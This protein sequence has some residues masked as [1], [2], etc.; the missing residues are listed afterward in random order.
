MGYAQELARNMKGFQ[1][2]AISFSIICI[3]SGGINSLGQ[4]IG[5]VGGAAIGIGWILGCGVS[6][7]FALGMA[8]IGSA[9]P[10]AGGLYHWSST[11][12]G[13]GYGWLTA[14]LNLIGLVT[15]L[16]AINVGTYNFFIGAFGPSLGL[17]ASFGLQA[18]FVIGITVIQS[19]VNHVG[20]RATAKLTDLSGYLIFAVAV[21]LTVALLAYA[22]SWEFS[23]LWTFKNYSGPAGGDVWPATESMLFLFGLGLLLPI[24]TITGFDASAHTA[25]ETKDAS[26]AV[27]KGI[28]NSVVW[29]ALFGWVM[30]SAF[31]LAIP[32]MDKAAASGWGVFFFTL[33]AVLPGALK[34]VLYVLIFVCQFI[35]GLATVTSASRMIFAFARDGGLPASNALKRVHPG[36]RTPVAAIWTAALI[37]IAFTLYT[38]AYATIVSVTVIFIFIS[39]GLPVIA[40][41]FAYG[42]TW[43]QM[44]PWDMGPAYRVVG[45]LAIAAIALI[46]YLGV[47]PPN[48]AALTITL[49]FLAIT[50]V[51][52]FGFERRRFKGPPV[53]DEVAKRQAEIAAAENALVASR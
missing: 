38:P 45:V 40:G 6:F 25:E 39:Y 29:S 33:D 51:V 18:A 8:Q 47:Q 44:G 30:L 21:G 9:Y 53:G 28:I 2:F 14:W 49:V 22:P 3:L 15:V 12:G 24:Y 16:G 34:Q 5:G 43:T 13:R 52:W 26:R 48:G 7:I 23:R 27:P 31:V 41:L 46:F 17:T 1:N 42:N 32:D 35:C 36:F 20:I 50:A 11:L 19:I 37:S 4:G 10:T